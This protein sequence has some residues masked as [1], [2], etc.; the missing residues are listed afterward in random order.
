MIVCKEKDDFLEDTPTWVADLSNGERI[1]Q[2]DSRPGVEP[3]QAW[4]RL[5]EYLKIHKLQI[6][7]LF[8]QNRSHFEFPL[9][10]NAP[11][12]FFCKKILCDITGDVTIHSYIIG[13][14][15]MERV[16]RTEWVVPALIEV[17]RDSVLEEEL[18]HPE[19]LIKNV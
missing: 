11:G 12:Y 10:E 8:L 18:L 17:E 7:R 16:F 9:P 15:N 5:A 1:W 3:P 2:D 6:V 14:W 13:F 4:Y 19:W